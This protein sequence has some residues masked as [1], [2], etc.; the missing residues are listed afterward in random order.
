MLA[1]RL[2]VPSALVAKSKKSDSEKQVEI[3]PP[4]DP[5]R[6]H[7]VLDRL[8][9]IYEAGTR[10][11]AS[12]KD[13]DAAITGSAEIV[14]DFIG[15]SH[16]KSEEAVFPRLRKVGKRVPLVDTLLAQH[17]AGR[18][19]TQSILQFAPGRLRKNGSTGANLE[20]AIGIKGRSPWL[21]FLWRRLRWRLG[22]HPRYPG[23]GSVRKATQP[24]LC[25]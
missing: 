1:G 15:N 17:Q 13:F 25:G 5:M 7:G 22:S 18:R 9:L 2:I 21:D 4:E 19:V 10:K 14:G 23:R 3:P 24:H 6:E 11:F 12:N 16:E 20:R 8:L